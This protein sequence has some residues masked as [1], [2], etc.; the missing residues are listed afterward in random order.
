M[1]AREAMSR[2]VVAW[3]PRSANAST[4]P[5]SSR[6]AAA[7]WTCSQTIGSVTADTLTP[8]T[9]R[10][11]LSK[12]LATRLTPWGG[13]DGARHLQRGPPRIPCQR[14]GVLRPLAGAADGA[15]PRREDDRPC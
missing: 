12:R 6:R 9:K 1:P 5:V 14:E 7:G 2:V 13:P 8:C 10:V 15:V 3:Y 11:K 4:A